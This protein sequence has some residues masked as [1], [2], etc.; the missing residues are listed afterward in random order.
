MY[1]MSCWRNF[2]SFL[3]PLYFVKPFWNHLFFWWNRISHCNLIFGAIDVLLGLMNEEHENIISVLNYCSPADG[4]TLHIGDLEMSGTMKF[5]CTFALLRG[6]RVILALL[7]L[8]QLWA[9]FFICI[10][11]KWPPNCETETQL[12]N[13]LP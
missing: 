3:L 8:W 4:S 7:P 5:F 9:I 13:Y 6:P 11:P 2:R 12:L 1:I 10:K